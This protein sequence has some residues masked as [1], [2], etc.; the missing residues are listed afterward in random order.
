[1]LAMEEAPPN[2]K[3]LRLFIIYVQGPFRTL[4][5]FVVQVKHKYMF[6][7]KLTVQTVRRKWSKHGRSA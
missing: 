5:I 3:I 1:M 7:L 4:L 6:V 2:L